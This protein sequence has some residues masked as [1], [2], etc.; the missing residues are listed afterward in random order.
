MQ[1]QRNP[2]FWLAVCYG[3]E[4]APVAALDSHPER[5]A[6][7]HASMF[8]AEE[9]GNFHVRAMVCKIVVQGTT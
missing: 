4:N 9:L 6:K 7:S 1:L 8:R 5:K 3:L 2:G